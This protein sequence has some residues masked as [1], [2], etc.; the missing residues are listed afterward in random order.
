MGPASPY[1]LIQSY[2]IFLF[3][4]NLYLYFQQ[5]SDSDSTVD[6]CS[7][8]EST[9]STKKQR[10]DSLSPAKSNNSFDLETDVSLPS[11]SKGSSG[12]SNK[13]IS[14]SDKNKNGKSKGVKKINRPEAMDVE[15]ISEEP[16]SSSNKSNGNSLALNG[17]G[18]PNSD[19][20]EPS[21]SRANTNVSEASGI[22]EA[23]PYSTVG[24]NCSITSQDSSPSQTI[25]G[26][27]YRRRR[28]SSS[29]SEEGNY[30]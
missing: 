11:T 24:A 25:R 15:P 16:L 1:S 23:P 20:S 3:V 28:A 7:D 5:Q 22:E 12:Y 21:V 29:D 18:S 9:E 10:N 27:N 4:I 14:K 26:R 8:N 30:I 13:K 17:S 6:N 19:A 2:D